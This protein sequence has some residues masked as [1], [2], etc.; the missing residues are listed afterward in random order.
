LYC[1]LR[2]RN[3]LVNRFA[4]TLLEYLKPVEEW[5]PRHPFKTEIDLEGDLIH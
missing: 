5:L 1:Y 3:P 4:G 2:H